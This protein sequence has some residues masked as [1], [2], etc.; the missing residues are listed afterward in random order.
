MIW[1]MFIKDCFGPCGELIE[2]G[3]EWKKEVRDWSSVPGKSDGGQ[4]ERADGA[5]ADA[6]HLEV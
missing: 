3:L 5:D 6:C 2:G 1:F 4:D